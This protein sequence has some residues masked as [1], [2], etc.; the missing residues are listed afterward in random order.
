LTRLPDGKLHA[1]FFDAGQGDSA[2]VV[3]PSGKQILID[4]GNDMSVLEHLG[5]YMPFFDRSIDLIVLSHP[6][7]DHLV[8][9]T[10]VLRR[11]EV[12]GI[13][14][15]SAEADLG[16]YLSFLNEIKTQSIPFLLPDP[17][18]HIYF[19]D[20]TVLD[21]I[22][23]PEMLGITDMNNRSLVFK[24]SSRG[25]SMLFTGDI[26]TKA[27]NYILNS[28]ADISADI[29][30]VAHHGSKTSSSE[31]FLDAVSPSLAVI[32]AE[33]NNSYG[34][35]NT[36]VIERLDRLEIPIKQTGGGNVEVEMR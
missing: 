14:A 10:E 23:P 30:K 32:T 6:N 16:R 20:E 8:S 21:V 15:S 36:E 11:Y 17:D 18:K 7:K 35:P 12:K 2:L 27:E 31:N 9:L 13:L 22:Y 34:F 26:E 3:T 33:I 4:G 1:Y 25:K 28:G 5:K 29:L 24:I 19:S